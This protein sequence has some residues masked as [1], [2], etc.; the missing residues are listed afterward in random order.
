MFLYGM[1]KEVDTK[2]QL[3]KVAWLDDSEEVKKGHNKD[4]EC[5][6][7]RVDPKIGNAQNPQPNSLEGVVQM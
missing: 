3:R 1:S 7:V 2:S 6:Q 5:L 4:Q